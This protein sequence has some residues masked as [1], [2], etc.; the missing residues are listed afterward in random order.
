MDGTGQTL[1][2]SLASAPKPSFEFK[3]A[4]TQKLKVHIDVPEDKS[5]ATEMLNYGCVGILVGFKE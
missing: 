1:F 2:E 4:T 3:V 5:S